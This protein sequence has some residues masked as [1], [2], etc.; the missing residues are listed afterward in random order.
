DV[1]LSN[2]LMRTL[3][4]EGPS[5]KDLKIFCDNK[6]SYF[7]KDVLDVTNNQSI[8][9]QVI[10]LRNITP[11]HE[12]NEAKTNFIATV[13]HE[14]KTPLSSI[15][16]S[17]RLLTD[18]RVGELNG[19][20]QELIR[21]ITDDADRLLKITGELLN[22]SQVETGNI[23]LKLQPANPAMIV[24]QAIQAVAFQAQQKGIRIDSSVAKGLPL[25]QA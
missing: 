18:L 17:A 10:V 16:M 20:Q 19:E 3:L 13:S 5:R 9:G 2:D 11:F 15:K 23:Q 6:E 21:T 4:Q 24:E 25:I 1:A 14:L 12:L 8:I 7:S 22:M